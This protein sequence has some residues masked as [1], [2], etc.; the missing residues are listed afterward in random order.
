MNIENEKFSF[1]F[2][3]KGPVVI[4]N[5]IGP[6]SKS[7]SRDVEECIHRCKGLH[8]DWVIVN[9]RDVPNVID[10]NFMVPA[11]ARF[12]KTIREH[13]A[14]LL[15]SGLHPEIKAILKESGCLRE[16]ELRN[17]LTEALRSL[18]EQKTAA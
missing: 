16:E 10:K 5:L 6:I 18:M 14:K 2:S 11:L 3:E 4:I 1:F 7:Y 12:Q 13:K 9:F 8:A 17:N 15:I